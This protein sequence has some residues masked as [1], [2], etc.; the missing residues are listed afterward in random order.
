MNEIVANKL[1]LS[2]ENP[3]EN[4]VVID[5]GIGVIYHPDGTFTLDI[6]KCRGILSAIENRWIFEDEYTLE[7]LH[8]LGYDLIQVPGMEKRCRPSKEAQR[9]ANLEY[10][11]ERCLAGMDRLLIKAK[12]DADKANN[13][14]N[15][16]RNQGHPVG[17]FRRFFRNLRV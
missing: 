15:S 16:N 9:L 13:H 11:I 14:G 2:V 4:Q 6:R 10:D 7:E 1:I 12:E 17:A 3:A 5:A 8:D